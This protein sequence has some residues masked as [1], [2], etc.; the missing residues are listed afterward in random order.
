MHLLSPNAYAQAAPLFEPF[1]FHLSVP[2]ALRGQIPAELYASDLHHPTSAMLWVQ[3]TLCLAGSPEN[4]Q[5]NLDLYHLFEESI[6]PAHPRN[7][8]TITWEDHGWEQALR[9]MILL[10][11]PP[12]IAP[13]Q[14][15]EIDLNP[16]GAQASGFPDLPEGL[17]LRAVD[18][19]LAEDRSFA[20]LDEL[21]EELLSERPSVEAFLE[22]SF[23]DCIVSKDLIVTWCLSEYNLG[24]RCEVGIA[25]HPDYRGRGLAALTGKVFLMQAWDAGICR[26]GWH[27]WTRNEASGKTALKIGLKLERDYPACW[28]LSDRAALFSVHGEIDLHQ[29]KYAGAAQWFERAAGLGTLPDWACMNAARAYA[30]LEQ[31]DAAFRYLNLAVEKGVLDFNELDADEHLQPLRGT[32]AWEEMMARNRGT[33]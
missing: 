20:N 2:S 31:P 19:G 17:A 7:G 5:F 14:Y 11:H 27:C 13:R 24:D 18:P 9:Q 6:F 10:D 3:H 32:K 30:R 4:A 26:V 23:G 21:L 22:H 16:P 1:D 12:I 8:F 29:G 15:Y 33:V 25:T 28:V